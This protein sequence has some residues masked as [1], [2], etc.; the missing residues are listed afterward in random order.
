M[1]ESFLITIT[2]ENAEH[3]FETRILWLGYLHKIEVKVFN[4]MVYFEPDEER[5]YRAVLVDP[6]TV[7]TTDL[8]PGLLQAIACYLEE[9]VK[10]VR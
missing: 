2:Y 10:L 1:D 3:T 9:Q 5:N 8:K 6:L 7:A 4:T